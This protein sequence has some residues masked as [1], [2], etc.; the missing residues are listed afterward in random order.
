MSLITRKTKPA[1]SP[2]EL[3]DQ[4]RTAQTEH[5]Q[6]V[7]AANDQL[8]NTHNSVFATAS[9]RRETLKEQIQLLTAE[10]D[11]LAPVANAAANPKL[12]GQ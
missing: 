9:D 1:A 10:H 7:A 5:A 2:A 12:A 11:A 4:L 6:A 3:Q 8:V